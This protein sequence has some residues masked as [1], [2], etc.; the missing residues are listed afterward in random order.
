MPL[1]DHFRPPLSLLRPWESFHTTWATALADQ[2]NRD[3]LPPG[4]IALEQVHAGAAI[5]I[6]VGTYAS[7]SPAASAGG[8]AT[9]ARTVWLPATAPVVMPAAFPPSCTVEI[10]MTEGGRTLV[11]AIEL[12]S[13]G[14]K[15]RD[16]KRRLFAAKCATCLSRGI[17]LVVI[18]VVASRQGNLHN[19]LLSLVG[20]DAT[21]AMA[22][23]AGM[24]A[25]AYRPLRR[26]EA[27]QVETWPVPLALGAALPTLPLSLAADFCVPVDL[28]AAYAEACQ[29]RRVAEVL[30]EPGT[31]SGR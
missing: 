14:N 9:L 3:V 20:L 28:E 7:P 12:V 17:G 16:V 22:R 30:G 19:E 23:D 5:E 31:N 1:L 11:A 15:D 2:L 8:T 26:G 6:D 25:V 24:Y 29:R 13:P 4:F 27:E 18:D 21:L 10:Q